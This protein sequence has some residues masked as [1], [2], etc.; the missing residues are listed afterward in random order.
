MGGDFEIALSFV[1]ILYGTLSLYLISRKISQTERIFYLVLY[2]NS[3]NM[4]NIKIWHIL[5]KQFTYFIPEIH[6]DEEKVKRL[7]D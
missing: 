7:I 4:P 6:Y 2:F 1:I 5:Q 3:K